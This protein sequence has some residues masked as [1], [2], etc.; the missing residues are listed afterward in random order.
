[1]FPGNAKCFPETRNVSLG[2]AKCFPETRNV[3]PIVGVRGSPPVCE[4][5]PGNVPV[6]FRNVPECSGYVPAMFRNV[7]VMFR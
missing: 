5:D 2:N 1:M 6:M 7:P 4:R 3:S